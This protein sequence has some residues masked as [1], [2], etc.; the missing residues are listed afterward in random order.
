M[1]S[2]KQSL[3]ISFIFDSQLIESVNAESIDVET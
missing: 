1:L 2:K 3:K